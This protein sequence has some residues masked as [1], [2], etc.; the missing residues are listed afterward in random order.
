MA[1]LTRRDFLKGSLATLGTA[2]C[3]KASGIFD[4]QLVQAQSMAGNGNA[5]IFI[6]LDGGVDP[7][8]S[9][10]IP[11][12]SSAYYTTR[13]TIGIASGQVRPT[14]N[15]VRGFHPNLVN[16][17]TMFQAGEVAVIQ[18]VGTDKPS[19]SHDTEQ[20]KYSRGNAT[21]SGPGWIGRLFDKA[22]ADGGSLTP[23][24]TITLGLGTP[25]DVDCVRSVYR[26]LNMSSV[27]GFNLTNQN[28]VDNGASGNQEN[29]WRREIHKQILALG[30]S[31]LIPSSSKLAMD[32]AYATIATVQ[33]ANTYW[34]TTGGP[35]QATFG[36]SAPGPRLRDACIMCQANFENQLGS[37]GTQIYLLGQ[38][39][40][41][42]HSGEIAGQN[43]LMSR[44]NQAI[45]AFR[46]RAIAR[47]WWDKVMIVLYSEF[48]RNLRENDS[49]GTDHGQAGT[50]VVVG[51]AVNGGV[52][53]DTISNAEFTGQKNYIQVSYRF[54][55]IFREL[56]QN[57]LALSTTGIWAD[58]PDYG[59]G[60]A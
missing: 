36:N 58:T 14:V 4:P 5:L 35:N 11:Y 32:S 23:F 25:S 1:K 46:N 30:T 45:N 33:A 13:P 18:R 59:F 24:N 19:F 27:G 52:Y 60:I 34:N 37:Q 17:H 55:S 56:V 41:D 29:Y 10:D 21:Y 50:I 49:G 53:G 12:G 51:G 16:L 54:E 15:G 31:G 6:A 22:V 43:T 8:N 3:A 57:H 39:G 26:P 44:L 42:L 28:G 47:G 2:C 38:G 20:E 7:L 9:F 48:G 40:H